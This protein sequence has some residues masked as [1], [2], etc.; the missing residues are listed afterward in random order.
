MTNYEPYKRVRLTNIC[1]FPLHFRSVIAEGKDI[2]IPAGA[3]NWE[4]LTMEEVRGQVSNG[5]VFFVGTNG[6][7]DH[8][9]VKI[10]D[11]GVR[12]YMFNIEVEPGVGV[13][14]QELMDEATIRE[15]LAI[16]PQKAFEEALEKAPLT[17]SDKK[18]LVA[19]VAQHASGD[20]Q[21]YKIKAIN[22]LLNVEI[23]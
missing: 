12:A 2:K 15:L 4:M 17:N 19:Y 1:P 6:M 11:E 13:P 9:R 5:N 22:A 20:L 23:G 3:K 10:E 21:A 14:A 18:A 7:G 16:T 8:A